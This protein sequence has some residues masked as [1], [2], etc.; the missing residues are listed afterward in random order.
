MHSYL[1]D[2]VTAPKHVPRGGQ[3]KPVKVVEQHI[4]KNKIK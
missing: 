3:T 1:L 4:Q 2:P